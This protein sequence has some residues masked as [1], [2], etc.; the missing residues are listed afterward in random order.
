MANEVDNISKL[1][2]AFSAEY[3]NFKTED[4]FRNYIN[5]AD[6]AKK[7]KLYKAFSDVYDNFKSRDEFD[8]YVGW[9]SKPI[10]TEE[11]KDGKAPRVQFDEE[12]QNK[13]DNFSSQLSTLAD[14]VNASVDSKDIW[15]MDAVPSPGEGDYI[16]P[17]AVY[18]PVSMRSDSNKNAAAARYVLDRTRFVLDNAGRNADEFRT[19]MQNLLSGIGEGLIDEKN[20]KWSDNYKQYQKA[21]DK[22]IR[23]QQKGKELSE[24]EKNL[25][26]ALAL[27]EAVSQE[28][29]SYM[30]HATELGEG[31]GGSIP[32]MFRQGL[33]M[34]MTGG[35]SGITSAIKASKGLGVAATAGKVALGLGKDAVAQAGLTAT[36]MAGI[37]ADAYERARGDIEYTVDKDGKVQFS[38]V[39]GISD[40][41]FEEY[42]KA[43]GAEY[44]EN[45]SE[46]LGQLFG[47]MGKF[48]TNKAKG[49]PVLG[50]AIKWL[51]RISRTEGASNIISV[52]RSAGLNDIVGENM[53]EWIGGIANAA[54]IGDQS[55]RDVFS[56]GNL[57]DTALTTAILCGAGGAASMVG[58]VS[59]RYRVRKASAVY[60]ENAENLFPSSRDAEKNGS[61]TWASMKAEIDKNIVDNPEKVADM[62]NSLQKDAK[63]TKQQYEQVFGYASSQLYLRGADEAL[64]SLE[65]V[66]PVRFTLQR[67]A[68][69][70]YD[71]NFSD[72][73]YWEAREDADAMIAEGRVDASFADMDMDTIA[74]YLNGQ[75]KGDE[76]LM[77]YAQKRAIVD[78]YKR[79]IMDSTYKYKENV[80]K[81]AQALAHDK[82]GTN[83][84]PVVYRA[85]FSD[86]ST[87]FITSGKVGLKTQRVEENG[88]DMVKE[89]YD[90]E[91]TDE[92]L[93]ITEGNFQSPYKHTSSKSYVTDIVPIPLEDYIE[94][95][96][97][98]VDEIIRQN[99]EALDGGM[100]ERNALNEAKKRIGEE[101]VIDMDGQ[102]VKAV[103]DGVT[104]DGKVILKGSKAFFGPAGQQV[105]SP[106]EFLS[107]SL[108][109]VAENAE[110]GAVE[111]K[112]DK[113][114]EDT[115]R[116]MADSENGVPVIYKGKQVNAKTNLEPR[117]GSIDFVYTDENGNERSGSMSIDEFM[118]SASDLVTKQAQEAIDVN[119]TEEVENEVENE[120]APEVEEAPQTI[121]DT[122]PEDSPARA[123]IA[124]AMIKVGGDETKAAKAIANT[125][126][127]R[128]AE[129]KKAQDIV[130]SDIKDLD[131]AKEVAAHRKAEADVARLA[132]EVERYQAANDA[133]VAYN[134]ANA[135]VVEEAPAPVVEET[136]PVAEPVPE[137]VVE[138]A[139][140]PVVEP[141]PAPV[142]EPEP[143][144]EEAPKVEPEPESVAPK[145]LNDRQPSEHHGFKYNENGVCLNPN[146]KSFKKGRES[147]EI[148]T[149]QNAD[150]KWVA[151]VNTM[152]T[153]AGMA[154]GAN[155]NSKNVFD[156]E[157]EAIRYAAERVSS[158]ANN[159]NA[160]LIAK[161]VQK[162]L[163]K[164]TPVAEVKPKPERK[165]KA[166]KE[167]VVA[168]EEDGLVADGSDKVA[169]EVDGFKYNEKGRC[170]NPEAVTFEKDGS[171]YVISVAKNSDGR[172]VHNVYVTDG[173][174]SFGVEGQVFENGTTR[175]TKEDAVKDG[176]KFVD[177]WAK[178]KAKNP[179]ALEESVKPFIRNDA[180]I[181]TAPV[182]EKKE[183]SKPKE[184]KKAVA[185]KERVLTPEVAA[186]R[187]Q[188]DKMLKMKGVDG[189]I[190]KLKE[191]IDKDIKDANGAIS[192]TKRKIASYETV[193]E[194]Y[195]AKKK[196]GGKISDKETEQFEDAEAML[197]ESRKE[198]EILEANKNAI[199][200]IRK[201]VNYMVATLPEGVTTV[202]PVEEKKTD[203][204]PKVTP[205]TDAIGENAGMFIT[206]PSSDLARYVPSGSTVKAVKLNGLRSRTL[207][208]GKARYKGDIE[209]LYTDAEGVNHKVSASHDFNQNNPTT[210]TV[211]KMA[212]A[213]K[214]RNRGVAD[215]LV[216]LL[217]AAGIEVEFTDTDAAYG[218]VQDGKIYLNPNLLNEETAIHEY[219]H[220]WD[221]AYRKAN[222]EK[223][224]RFKELLKQTDEWNAVI[225]DEAYADI[226]NDEDLV[227]SEVHSRLTGRLGA[228][229]AS[230]IVRQ[231]NGRTLWS[232][233]SDAIRDIADFI[234]ETFAR[235]TGKDYSQ[236]ALDRFMQMPIRDIVKGTELEKVNTRRQNRFIGEEGAARLDQYD[237]VNRIDSLN[238]ARA[239]ELEGRDAL[240]IKKATG[241]ERGA[242]KKWKY[243]T[244]D[245]Q[246]A[247]DMMDYVD[248]EMDGDIVASA[249]LADIIIDDEL[250]DAY[251]SLEGVVV[252]FSEEMDS[253]AEFTPD[254]IIRVGV[255]Y[256]DA[257]YNGVDGA[258]DVLRKHLLHE[259]QHAIQKQEGFAIGGDT[260]TRHDLVAANNA[261]ADFDDAHPEFVAEYKKLHGYN[262]SSR[263][264]KRREAF[265]N[266]N[267]DLVEQY[268]DILK[269]IRDIKNAYA[270]A[271]VDGTFEQM[272]YDAYRGLAGEVEA[273]N[274]SE[275]ADMTEEERRNSLGFDTEDVS[276]EDQIVIFDMIDG[277][278][279]TSM[280]SAPAPQAAQ[281][282][283]ADAYHERLKSKVF[284]AV[285][286][287]QDNQMSVR[288]AQ[289]AIQE[290]TGNIPIEDHENYLARQNQKSSIDQTQEEMYTREY[291]LPLVNAT[292]QLRDKVNEAR[293]YG[294]T[295]E[296]MAQ[297][298]D[299]IMIYLMCKHGLERNAYINNKKAQEA[300][301]KG[302][303]YVEV[304]QSGVG[305]ALGFTGTY[306]DL[307]VEMQRIVDEFEN[308]FGTDT[309]ELW[310]LINK[311]TDWQ[312]DH[313]YKSGLLSRSQRDYIRDMYDFYIPLRG[314]DADTAEDV[315]N[316]VATSKGRWAKNDKTAEGRRS[317]AGNPIANI[318]NMAQ[319]EIVQ[320]NHNVVKQALYNY[321]VNRPNDLLTISGL[322]AEYDPATD[323]WN[324]V[325][326]PSTAGM[327][328]ED[329]RKTLEAFDNMMK[330]RQQNGELVKP[331]EAKDNI[332]YRVI[333]P[334]DKNQHYI[335]VKINGSPKAIIV[336]GDPRVAQA[337]NGLL[338]REGKENFLK[339]VQ[340][341]VQPMMTNYNLDFL[342]KNWWR[343]RRY[344]FLR[345]E[346]LEGFSLKKDSYMGKYF[347]ARWRNNIARMHHYLNWFNAGKFDTSTFAGIPENQLSADQLRQKRFAE[348][349][350]YGGRTGYTQVNSAVE[351]RRALLNMMKRIE[352]GAKANVND[353][354]PAANGIESFMKL[355]LGWVEHLNECVE[356]MTRF[357]VYETS[358]QMGRS[359]Q[360]SVS[361]AK[362][363][364]VN[365]NRRGV[366][367]GYEDGGIAGLAAQFLG[368]TKFFF[369]AGVQGFANLA[370]QAT[371]NTTDA[372]KRTGQRVRF[373]MNMARIMAMGFAL[374]YLNKLISQAI[375]PDGD[376]DEYMNL[377]D[378]VRHSNM[379]VGA[380]GVYVTFPMGPEERSIY[381]VGDLLYQLASGKYADKGRFG[382][383]NVM[384]DIIASAMGIIPVNP[385]EN[386]TD[387]SSILYNTIMP[388]ILQPIGDVMANKKYT[389]A[390]IYKNES[391]NKDLPGY[392]KCYNSTPR[393]LVKLS[394]MLYKGQIADLNPAPLFYIAQSYFSGPTKLLFGPIDAIFFKALQGEPISGRDIPIFR[395]A[396]NIM[397]D[398]DKTRFI[399]D[400]YR[401]YEGIA[402]RN[403]NYIKRSTGL[404]KKDEIYGSSNPV[405][406][407]YRN[408]DLSR[409]F[410]LGSKEIEKLQRMLKKDPDNDYLK[411][412]YIRK[413]QELVN[414]LLEM[415]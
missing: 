396:V 63:I 199:A 144:V 324:T 184:K 35:G 42:A 353:I 11:A 216:G 331:L 226:R 138:T 108:V 268:E 187:K 330:T 3:D 120:A 74:D 147:Y 317:K 198:L 38:G 182:E 15:D 213:P 315:Y 271:Q 258:R 180:E 354:K 309:D 46:S 207:D 321:V 294:D 231:A 16:N 58:G 5:T 92:V 48:V 257:I 56:A 55:M 393:S 402:K 320:G 153:T 385:L 75:G 232:R 137:P 224:N 126:A 179:A 80:A 148:Y 19:N 337:V 375:D 103:V 117:Q 348:F 59:S 255:E 6:D 243:E 251:P 220:L 82:V 150:G 304:D 151:G 87:G 370:E 49:V 357:S 33:F 362:D 339:G 394:E 314:F 378:F 158:W 23:K 302:L 295:R 60:D 335:P 305:D 228:E 288:A 364:S 88:V 284:K 21:I 166:K 253:V 236:M 173:T 171:K 111:G 242:D 374:P 32:F 22:V 54:F 18:K 189:D 250:F 333:N 397:E 109:R 306:A 170:L 211:Q 36:E 411:S 235:I 291:Y 168:E 319:T 223:W 312:L 313:A 373:G 17:D 140:E 270:D 316:Y 196:K 127:E 293:S 308:A 401:K 366:Q 143:V 285:E 172:W 91:S 265:R 72:D 298:Y 343:D 382:M 37:A 133:F 84:E 152:T 230:E 218:Y 276:R 202:A 81:N 50:D 159:N 311:A 389:G 14:K 351:H 340:R 41:D 13:Y 200:P 61:Y 139:P 369:N 181:K 44:I 410:Y 380:K 102:P 30:P 145:P 303:N 167:T 169:K 358:R 51:G 86:G 188:I 376:D 85:T 217:K 83:G 300:L 301:G 286:Q 105:M 388:D 97:A 10:E 121:L 239:M 395:S 115:I 299:D 214:N 116:A 409:E 135:P 141:E 399:D 290:A 160:K 124:D 234:K 136:A 118:T 415:E 47:P 123:T 264:E 318:M 155:L 383:W 43:T 260:R 281:N 183:E 212:Y 95:E 225:N 269:R 39:S 164:D 178:N 342:V 297:A 8:A 25:L 66:D 175:E 263:T 131:D 203:A 197:P 377:P 156:T 208:D 256:L 93:T 193:I 161:D 26:E 176:Y 349:M 274:V 334:M 106:K 277:D 326:V 73:N 163:G 101:A 206:L 78:A 227:A 29:S 204:L 192:E 283:A 391:Y 194:K 400:A 67:V 96:Q 355:S 76:A 142:A 323:A 367:G 219:T 259:V 237:A 368:E 387:A 359:V 327:S 149:A 69:T 363:I 384:L 20:Y 350:E 329:A 398:K 289:D 195:N 371:G 328:E 240:S 146:T 114:T 403:F 31:V 233:I 413:K 262:Y 201:E 360:K 100:S 386:A 244:S 273:R 65:K 296:G 130:D 414:K 372:K 390:P 272:L 210:G 53:E 186:A 122:L 79:R 344:S 248:E 238:A 405:Y 310:K 404:E 249:A 261:E 336:N 154:S 325:P 241:W 128:Q 165:S 112:V 68:G 125:L 365:F 71:Q 132:P 352:R 338:G 77:E 307:T 280:M 267:A 379:A 287:F 94:N 246:L 332:G 222:P 245:F 278:Y 279:D 209:I 221:A 254:G 412:E 406:S 28:I 392:E 90:P 2:K 1:Y 24:D 27:N 356:I 229:K 266:E 185:S 322:W 361:D 52:L 190:V 407:T 57:T 205:W 341:V 104:E 34:A 252:E 134:A 45:F 381:A 215:Q 9:G 292:I 62:L 119:T 162:Y 70:I 7:G 64:G 129:L 346:N 113:T 107:M 99:S 275:R 98:N 345:I 157:E 408:Y 12:T 174:N 89:V 40:V 247:E 191:R 177:W 347:M 110:S 282:A 4:D